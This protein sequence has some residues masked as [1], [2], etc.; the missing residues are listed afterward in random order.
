MALLYDTAS[1]N[2]ERVEGFS[3]ICNPEIDTD[4]KQITSSARPAGD[5]IDKA[6]NR[7]EAEDYISRRAFLKPLIYGE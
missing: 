1:R 2:L 3:D 5:M 7:Q 4:N 6:D